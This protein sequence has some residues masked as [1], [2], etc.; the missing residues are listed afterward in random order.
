MHR[1]IDRDWAER[2]ASEWIDGWN[3]HDLE[4][5]FSHYTDD[6]EMSSPFIVEMMKV[7]SGVL[8]GKVA[9]RPYWTAALE[10][11]PPIKFELLGVYVGVDR[12]GIHY[13]S[14]GRRL[15]FEVLTFNAALQVTHGAA[16]YG[17]PA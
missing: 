6:F 5:I 3:S 4:R 13:R 7:P 8:R 14:V 17:E 10:R 15:A 12:I 16:H 1:M 11:K 9:I 2:F